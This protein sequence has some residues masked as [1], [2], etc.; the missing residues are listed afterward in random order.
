VGA[1][2]GAATAPRRDVRTAGIA[3]RVLTAEGRPAT[4]VTVVVA[5]EGPETRT[6]GDGR[7]RL[8]AEEGATVRLEA[9]HSD[10][11]YAMAEARAPAASVELRLAPRAG[12]DVQ[13]LSE[14]RPVTGASIT[15]RQRSG[16]AAL[17]HSDRLTDANGALRFLGLPGGSLEVEAL[18]AET[19]AR[20]SLELEG[21]EGSVAR[22]LLLLPVVGVV[23]GTVVTRDGAPVS[24]AFVGVE[25]AEGLPARSAE[26]GTFVLKGLRTGRDYRLTA[27]TPELSQDTPVTVRA[28]QSDVRLVVRERLVY[29]GRVVGPGG[30][31]LRTFSVEGRAFETGDGRFA[32]PLQ[33]RDGQLEF[34]VAAD[35]MLTRTVVA[36]GTV[37]E[38]GDLGMQ[39]AP[40]L[41]G[42]VT[43]AT[44]QPA[45]KAEVSA[46]VDTARSDATGAFTLSVSEP[47]PAGTPIVVHAVQ[48]DL[49]GSA[50]APLGT[51][52]GIV[53]A[54]EQPVRVRVFGPDGAPAGGRA[55]QLVG[56]RT[57]DWTTGPDGT[58]SGKAL[59]GEY[60]ASTDAQ[61]GRV[62][63][64]RLPAAEVL[65]G[66]GPG[67][68]SLEVDVDAPLEALWVEKGIAAG[69]VSSDRP[70][71]RG[72]GQLLFGVERSARFDGLSP[73][74]WTVV[75]L[76]QG[77]AVVRTVQVSGATRLSL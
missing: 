25:P 38:L 64:V 12:L 7:F 24:G 29:R 51:Q 58:V 19:G 26:D 32:M 36:G 49:A 5:P 16:E 53:L 66:S 77:T 27:R 42:R 41:Q 63:F 60:R 4:G 57:Y 37:S 28:G 45:A 35:G 76:R 34:R 48:G 9:H 55:V 21:R 17:F 1:P 69:P 40:R 72:E 3:G 68:A 59:A 30:A 50:E 31:P 71:P 44:G 20:G 33:P 43:L 22:V 39:P 2:G 65:L 61:P 18:L 52:V 62:W 8:E 11:G 67:A 13:V 15:V 47:P 46:G 14:G 56:V 54:G 10:L 6:A 70:G 75:G 74:S 23:Q 73:G